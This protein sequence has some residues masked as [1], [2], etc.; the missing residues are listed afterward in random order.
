VRC[1]G[2]WRLTG[3]KVWTSAAQKADWGVCL[4]RTNPDA[5][6]H[7]GIT[8]F[9]VDMRSAGIEIRPLRELTGEAMFNEVFLD[10]VFVP[11]EL[12]VG[13]VDGGWPLARTTL[14]H[15]RVAMGRGSSLGEDVED[16]VQQ[17]QGRTDDAAVAQRLGG[18][19]GEG[20]AGSLLD[21][22][23]T[24]RRLAGTSD[25][26][27]AASVR[28]L[29]GVAHR[30]AVTEA[31]VELLGADGLVDSEQLRRFLH[32]RCLSIAGGTTQVLLT[33]AAERLLGL[34]RG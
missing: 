26:G 34:P 29:V 5:P 19:I 15:E 18:L 13:D 16:L 22:R 8:Y 3:Q 33:L 2:G 6:K 11:D 9:L 14:S 23:T 25:D 24:L 7:R 20:L 27:A 28:K 17:A 32:L 12:V 31:A 10:D 21:L 1:E 4:A 30:Q